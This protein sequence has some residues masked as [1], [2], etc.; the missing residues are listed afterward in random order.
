MSTTREIGIRIALG[1]QIGD[2]RDYL[3]RNLEHWDRYGHGLWILRGRD[4]GRFVGRSAVRHVELG[5]KD[6]IEVG[7]ALMRQHWGYGLATEIAR[8]MI[9]LAFSSLGITDLVAFTLLE[10]VASRRV[11]EKAG[12]IY[13]RDII[14][15]EE[16]H[17]L[18]RFRPTSPAGSGQLTVRVGD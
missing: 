12:G 18:Y 7:Y 2:V 17:M 9:K 4:D 1:A 5:G 13:E 16:L 11:M 6:E 3:Q 8:E 15:A 10:N 14:H